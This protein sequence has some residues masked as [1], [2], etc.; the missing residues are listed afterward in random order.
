[1]KNFE[2]AIFIRSKILKAFEKAERIKNNKAIKKLMKFVVIGGGPTGVE[3]AGAIAELSK[4][5][6]TKEFSSIDTKVAHIILLEAGSSILPTAPHN[7][8]IY[9]KDSL[10][11]LG[12][13]IK[14]NTVVQNI[15]ESL[16]EDKY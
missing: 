4:K 14:C 6:L 2:D 9:T 15:S 7:L 8:S 3:I 12:V 10:E 1:M 11:N 13:E 16:V 5:V